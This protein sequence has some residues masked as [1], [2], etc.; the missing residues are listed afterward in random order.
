MLSEP[1]ESE[2]KEP[3]DLKS[4]SF[5]AGSTF[6]FFLLGGACPGTGSGYA[7]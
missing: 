4:S 6:Y 2:S 5:L 7:V 1:S 3:I